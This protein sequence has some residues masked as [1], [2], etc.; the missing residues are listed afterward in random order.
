MYLPYVLRRILINN[1]FVFTN[2]TSKAYS[3]SVVIF[4]T[5]LR[6]FPWSHTLVAPGFP[7]AG[8]LHLKIQNSLIFTISILLFFRSNKPIEKRHRTNLRYFIL[9][10]D[11]LSLM[12]HHWCF[13]SH[14]SYVSYVIFLQNAGENY[15]HCF[16][17]IKQ[18]SKCTCVYLYLFNTF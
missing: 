7:C 10:Y 4:A 11:R 1:F 13:H 18:D 6:V 5:V 16:N 14:I 17:N 9:F 15:F 2:F 12:L 8:H 3:L